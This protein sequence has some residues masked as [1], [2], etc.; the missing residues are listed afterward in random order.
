MPIEYSR[1]RLAGLL[2]SYLDRF[3]VKRHADGAVVARDPATDET[4]IADNPDELLL[5]IAVGCDCL[6]LVEHPTID[7]VPVLMSELVGERT[8]GWGWQV[9]DRQGRRIHSP[10]RFDE[11]EAALLALND[12]YDE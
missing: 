5:A 10:R 9:V 11:R 7:G 6:D 3:E 8:E 4:I 12:A 1:A 2:M